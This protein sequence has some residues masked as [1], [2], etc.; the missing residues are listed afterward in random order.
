M[1]IMNGSRE[2]DNEKA[3]TST[4]LHLLLRKVSWLTVNQY[5][6]GPLYVID[7]GVYKIK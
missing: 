7:Y 2:D 5:M 1:M 3:S 6:K 4:V